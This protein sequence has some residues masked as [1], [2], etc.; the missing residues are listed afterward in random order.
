MEFHLAQVN[1]AGDKAAM[2]APLMAAK[3]PTARAF[4]FKKSYDPTGKALVRM[5]GEVS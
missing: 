1:I 5:K 2:D 4:M 3:G